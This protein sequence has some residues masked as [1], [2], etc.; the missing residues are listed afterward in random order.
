MG[1]ASSKQ[2]SD[3]AA[4]T[5]GNATEPVGDPARVTLRDLLDRHLEGVVTKG[6]TEWVALCPAHEDK[7]PSLCISVGPAYR[8]GLPTSKFSCKGCGANGDRVLAA[9]GLSEHRKSIYGLEGFNVQPKR[10]FVAPLPSDEQLANWCDHLRGEPR[11]MAYLSEHR[12]L[13]LPTLDAWYVGYDEAFD[14]YTLP[15]LNEAGEVVNV[16]RYDP[17]GRPKMRNLAG[18]GSPPRLYPCPPT[19]DDRAVVVAEGEWDAL[20]ARGHGLTA[21]SGTHGADTWRPEWSTA[22]RGRHVAFVY[23]CDGPGRE[24]APA[25]A[26]EVARFAKSVRVVDLAPERD[27]KWDLTDWFVS[28]R[29]RDELRALINAT[30]V[31]G[32]GRGGG[33]HG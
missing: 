11:L 10:K 24:Y 33:R 30:P 25:H 28:G 20:V 19:S 32:A 21:L 5:G 7:E 15:V 17:S 16:R 4:P 8:T 26:A 13:D 23:D 22:L 18:H 31:A 1:R 27:D 9:L 12:A 6:R 14:C 2:R 29:S 3:Q